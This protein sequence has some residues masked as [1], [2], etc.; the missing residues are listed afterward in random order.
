MPD[1]LKLRHNIMR[2]GDIADT[3]TV[4]RT[5]ITA[6]R[7]EKVLAEV[8]SAEKPT[9]PGFFHMELMALYDL[10]LDDPSDILQLNDLFRGQRSW[11]ERKNV[12]VALWPGGGIPAKLIYVVC[13]RTDQ[14]M[15]ETG[16]LQV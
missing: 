1:D 10:R 12:N 5:G 9:T 8:E 14:R 2:H 3:D 7:A 6:K 4:V 11:S 15:L 13:D 16:V